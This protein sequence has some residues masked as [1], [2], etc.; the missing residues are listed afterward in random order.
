MNDQFRARR[1]KLDLRDHKWSK[2]GRGTTQFDWEKGF[3][4]EKEIGFTLNPKD[5]NGSYSCGGQAGALYTAIWD[6]FIH[7]SYTEKSAKDMYSQIAYPGGGTTLRD[8]MDHARNKGVCLEKL[9]PSY[10]K[11][12]PPSE[13]FMLEK[14]QT[15][16]TISN[17]K[18]TTSQGYASVDIDIE[19]IAQAAA[20]NHGCIILMEGQNNGSVKSE[21][22]IPPENHKYVW[23]HFVYIG[24]AKMI[25]GKKYIGYLNSWGPTTGKNG[26]QWINASY[27]PYILEANTMYDA[28]DPA[29]NPILVQTQLSLMQKVLT[30]M[31]KLINNLFGQ[32]KLSG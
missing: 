6:F 19:S 31:Q 10:E 15:P 4:I 23:R 16:D 5:Q 28:K 29:I 21:F 17:A 9:I 8:M 22:P 13:R 1:S 30:L 12:Q 7:D 18:T 27:M 25:N 3:D 24:K 26:W 2:I 14:K 11:G 32:T 20:Y